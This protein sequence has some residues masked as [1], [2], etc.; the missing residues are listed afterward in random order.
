MK[1]IIYQAALFVGLSSAVSLGF[2]ASQSIESCI[3]AIQK[4]KPG[5]ISKLEKLTVSGKPFY[6]FEIKDA[7]GA[8]WEFMCNVQNGKVTETESESENADAEAFKKAMKISEKD[9][10][11]TALKAHPGKIVEVE[12]EIE[13]NGAPSYEFDIV[14]D[15]G[16]ET[17]VEVDAASG[18]IIEVSKEEWEIGEEAEEKR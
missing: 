14:N 18:K 9:A 16:V 3:K 15:K 10:S 1:K 7:T 5:E 12:Y 2:A 8:E 17:K 6:E 4:Q 11:D 13:S